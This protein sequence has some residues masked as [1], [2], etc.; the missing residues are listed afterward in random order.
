MAKVKLP[1][2]GDAEADRL[3][4]ENPLA[5]LLGMLLDQQITMEK[6][7]SGPA[8]L[9]DRLGGLDA[10]AIAEM[11]LD[12][13][14]A[15]CSQTPAI[16]RFPKSMGTRI[17]EACRFIT[18]RWNGDASRIWKRVKDADE[19]YRRLR[20]VPGFGDEKTRIFIALLAKRFGRTP[21]GWQ[22]VAEPFGDDVPRSVADVNDET[23]LI[24]VRE[25]KKAQKAAKRAA[26]SKA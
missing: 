12:D 15:V 3:L 16:H 6:A 20:E 19:L 21:E 1:I 25:W 22:R 26:G 4:S 10:A 17:W 14:I 13:F 9:A 5:L 23:S 8:V 18:E 24:A 7:F 11:P 2:T